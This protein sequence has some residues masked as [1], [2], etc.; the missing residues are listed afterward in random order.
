MTFSTSEGLA[1]VID[2][3]CSSWLPRF[4]KADMVAVVTDSYGGD[5]WLRLSGRHTSGTPPGDLIRLQVAVE[6][7]EGVV[8]CCVV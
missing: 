1:V 6:D 7:S 4:V 3:V 8:L 5:G 2:G